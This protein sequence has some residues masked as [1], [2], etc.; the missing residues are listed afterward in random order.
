M[1]DSQQFVIQ[2]SITIDLSVCLTGNVSYN[3]NVI[4]YE[5]QLTKITLEFESVSIF[6][7]NLVMIKD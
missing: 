1:Y 5:I 4:R 3:A 2:F 6:L 7:I